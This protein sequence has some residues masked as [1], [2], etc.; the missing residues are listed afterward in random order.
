MRDISLILYVI[1]FTLAGI[2]FSCQDDLE[3]YNSKIYYTTPQLNKIFIEEDMNTCEKKL[4]V[5]LAKPVNEDVIFS[6]VADTEKVLNYNLLYSDNAKLLPANYYNLSQTN[7]T[8]TAGKM[9]S[10]E[11]NIAFK[12]LSELDKSQIYV[13]PISISGSNLDILQS[14]RTVY[15]VI[16]EAS[17]INVVANM[18]EN[19]FSIKWN[20]AEVV[21]NLSELTAEFLINIDAF[22]N[23]RGSNI[24]TILGVEGHFLIRFG[25]E[26][27]IPNNQPQIAAKNS[28]GEEK[29]TSSDWVCKSGRWTHIAVTYSQSDHEVEVYIDGR[30]KTT[31]TFNSF[32]EKINW[33]KYFETE[34]EQN[35]SFWIGYSYSSD[36]Y[37]DGNI[38]E[39]RIWNRRL[40]EGEIKSENHF[41][42]V[43]PETDGLVAYWKLNEGTGNNIKDYTSN[44]NDAVTAKNVIW[45]TVELP[46]K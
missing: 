18:K 14:Q 15:Y 20:N 36:R 23:E 22:A 43:N 40:Q 17:L 24:S 46:A 5:T 8:I 12:E 34:T 26:K 6:L 25:D 10:D 9:F 45:K 11:V 16:K 41:Y 1:L 35:R 27:F 4:Q 13:L 32:N 33:G 39:C 7:V 21:N 30:K 3:N 44:G 29:L 31:Q 38:C 19:S 28:I 42:K 37:L 2:I